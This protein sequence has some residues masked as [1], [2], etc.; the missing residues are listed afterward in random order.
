[1]NQTRAIIEQRVRLRVQREIAEANEKLRAAGRVDPDNLEYKRYKAILRYSYDRN[2]SLPEA[3]A[4]W[5]AVESKCGRR[6]NELE[7][8]L[9]TK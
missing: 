5:M 1:M 6:I 3:R 8:F 2:M 4:A 9:K 7:T